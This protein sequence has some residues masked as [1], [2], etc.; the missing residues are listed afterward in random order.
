MTLELW[1]E[2]TAEYKG[3]IVKGSFKFID[4]MVTVRTPFGSKT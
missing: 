2:I 3:R 1:R 4:D